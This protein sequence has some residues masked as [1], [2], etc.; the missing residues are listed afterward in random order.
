M[1]GSE[2]F[3]RAGSQRTGGVLKEMNEDINA[4]CARST[5]LGPSV[6]DSFTQTTSDPT[7]LSLKEMIRRVQLSGRICS[8]FVETVTLERALQAWYEISQSKS[9]L[10]LARRDDSP[11]PGWTP[12]SARRSNGVLCYHLRSPYSLPME[13]CQL[14]LSLAT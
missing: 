9:I 7:A 3:L 11:L 10:F 5:F 8:C 4:Q 1:S 14:H 6:S 12:V 13:N 2:V